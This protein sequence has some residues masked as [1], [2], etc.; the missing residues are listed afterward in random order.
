MREE[1][2]AHVHHLMIRLLG[3]LNESVRFVQEKDEHEDFSRYRRSVGQ[4][5]EQ[6]VD[7]LNGLY[8]EYPSLQP[9]EL[10]PQPN[11]NWTFKG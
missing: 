3:E 1:V 11:D 6:L 8:A 9:P 2:A 7:I 5:M 10:R 4:V